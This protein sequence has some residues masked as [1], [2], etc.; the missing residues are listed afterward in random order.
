MGSKGIITQMGL[1]SRAVDRIVSSYF[2]CH[3]SYAATV[4]VSLSNSISSISFFLL[5]SFMAVKTCVCQNMYPR[6]FIAQMSL[7]DMYVK[8]NK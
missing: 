3:V 1:P 2:V 4:T 7:K 5:F 8:E 6:Y